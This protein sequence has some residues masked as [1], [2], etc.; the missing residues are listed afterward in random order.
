MECNFSES[1]GPLKCF[2]ALGDPLIF[3]LP[4]NEKNMMLKKE[5]I[6]TILN[7]N[8]LNTPHLKVILHKKYVDHCTFFNNGTLKINN[9]QRTDS[10]QYQLQTHGSNGIFLYEINMHLEIQGKR[11]LIFKMLL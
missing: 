10:G 9:A 4:M 6:S 11:F 7:L 3:H 2:G 8:K 5:N 1:M